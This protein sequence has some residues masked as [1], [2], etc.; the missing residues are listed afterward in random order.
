MPCAGNQSQVLTARIQLKIHASE[1][2]FCCCC[3]FSNEESYECPDYNTGGKNSCFFSKNDTSIWVN[4]NITVVATNR[5]G[6]SYSEPVDVDVVYIGEWALFMA[7]FYM[8]FL[9]AFAIHL[10]V[11][12]CP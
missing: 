6:S 12:F 7:L 1:L 2:G 3:V 8:L 11:C 4:Y 10:A 9:F 5:L